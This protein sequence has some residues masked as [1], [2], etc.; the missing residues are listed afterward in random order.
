MTNSSNP[1]QPLVSILICNY[2]YGRFISTA[3]ESALAQ[4]YSNVEIIVVD[5]GSK[6]NSREIIETYGNRVRAIFKSNG[7]QPSATNVAFAASSGDVICLLD[8]DDYYANDKVAKIVDCYRNHPEASFVFHPLR[9]IHINGDD[10]GI[11]EPMDGSRW[12]D[13]RSKTNKFT[14]PPT[15]G[16]TFRRSAWNTFVFMPEELTILG[17]NYITF[18]I[19]ALKRGFYLCEPLAV[20]RLHGENIFSMNSSRVFRLPAD[21]KV[22]FAMRKHFPALVEKADRLVSIT[23]AECWKMKLD[24]HATQIQLENY[25]RASAPLS[26][27]RIYSGA[28]LRFAKSFVSKAASSPKVISRPNFTSSIAAQSDTNPN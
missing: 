21:V 1:N 5:D 28:V 24:D 6:D 22:A 4:T 12:L 16:L 11:Q 10:H 8:A 7:G 20:L 17:D 18:V 9:R 13:Y 23:V 2:N 27:F 25:L 26:R 3:I 15:S 19:M 14:A